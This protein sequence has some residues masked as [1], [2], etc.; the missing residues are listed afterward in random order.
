MGLFNYPILMSADILMF[1]ANI[2]PVGQDQKQH[3]EMTRDIASRF[4][5]LYGEIFTIPEASIEK[6]K[7]ILPGIDGRKM[8]KSYEN[9]IPIFLNKD[10]LRKK[11]MK[12]K[13]DSKEPGEPKNSENSTVFNLYRAFA[14]AKDTEE[15]KKSFEEG[16]SWGEAKEI[17]FSLLEDSIRPYKENYQELIKDPLSLEKILLSGAEKALDISLP[18]IKQVRK[19]VGIRSFGDIPK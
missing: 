18:I 7:G 14:S 15:F 9:I 5:H 10:E 2:V 11:V 17:L 6:D 4:N 3:V 12:I 8:S 16:I 1:N 19:A 13:T